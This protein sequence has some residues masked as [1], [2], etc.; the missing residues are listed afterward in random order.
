MTEISLTVVG[1]PDD[2]LQIRFEADTRLESAAVLG[3]S[4]EI[5]GDLLAQIRTGRAAGAATRNLAETLGT[6]LYAGDVGQALRERL[7]DDPDT[8]VRLATDTR[9][10]E[11]PW[12]LARDP[13]SG[14]SLGLDGCVL[15]REVGA[16][17][18]AAP[19]GQFS[20]QAGTR[21][22]L[23][24]VRGELASAHVGTLQAATRPL[25]RKLGVDVFPV[26]PVT[27]PN[28][29]RTLGRGALFVHIEAPMQDDG[30]LLDD[31]PV[32]LERLGLDSQTYL[33]ILGGTE[34]TLP[35]HGRLRA[36]GVPVVL[37]LQLPLEMAAAAA[38][39]RELYRALG[40]GESVATAVRRAR[41]AL[42]RF[43]GAEGATWAAPVLWSAP[44]VRG[45]GSPA[46]L[47]FPP[48]REERRDPGATVLE[49]QALRLTPQNTRPPGPQS[50]AVPSAASG[51]AGPPLPAAV[52]IQETI[53]GI[54]EGRTDPELQARVEG[55]RV[56]GGTAAVNTQDAELAELPPSERTT[57]LADRLL[58]AL[59]RP[60]A[61]LSPPPDYEARLELAART[62]GIGLDRVRAAAGAILAGRGVALVGGDPG[63]RARL[64][65]RLAE[66]VFDFGVLAG[67]SA[68]HG[69]WMGGPGEGSTGLYKAVILNWRRDEIDPFR[70]DAP[71]P[72]QRICS[73][74][75]SA[76]GRYSAL[77]GVWSLLPLTEQ[78]GRSALFDLCEAVSLGV[79]TGTSGQRVFR[80]RVPADFRVLISGLSF[81]LLHGLLPA[82]IPIVS[83]DEARGLDASRAVA[84]RERWLASVESRLGP[85]VD[86]ADTQLRQ[87]LAD[88]LGDVF[89]AVSAQQAVPSEPFAAALRL[90]VQLGG[91]PEARVDEALSVFLGAHLH[92]DTVVALGRPLPKLQAAARQL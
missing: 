73:V 55:L 42:V 11:W 25:A 57:R 34:V 31:G 51:P 47:P 67:S 84:E 77:K 26:E 7:R 2:R 29:R 36:L 20:E 39:D 16:A 64:L 23:L 33:A 80:L 45:Q 3:P 6:V 28:L 65:H 13:E 72:V 74:S 21:R 18:T 1:G 91:A 87:K 88:L 37:G 17:L 53:R 70:L 92:R 56:L 19:G 75:R 68:G 41:R 40:A 63:Q 76:A 12:E 85:A 79:L 69:Q 9:V 48:P 10:A 59:S 32:P 5:M 38:L 43:G 52:F 71:G 61:E 78:A 58:D 90:A 27:G 14:A 49:M 66:D 15:L 89:A 35:L 46:A 82:D 44:A 83:L 30:L 54:R 4:S 24:V 22:A 81:D 50:A 60:D 8:I 62:V 86:V